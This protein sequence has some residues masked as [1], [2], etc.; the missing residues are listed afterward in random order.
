LEEAFQR[1][2]ERV[3]SLLVQNL[4]YKR[5]S[6]ILEAGCGKGQ[7]TVP[8][9]RRT[10]KTGKNI[11]I[12][13]LDTSVGP[14]RGHL[15]VLKKNLRKEKLQDLVVPVLADVRNMKSV[16]NESVDILLS[17]ELLCDLDRRGLEKA[18]REFYRVLKPGGQM[19]HAELSPV[20]ENEAQELLIEADANSLETSE[21]R[22]EWFSPFSD[23]VAAIMH[24]T[25]F[26]NVNVGYFETEI[27]MKYETAIATLRQ[28][29]IA[30][31]F[32][33]NRSGDI[34]KFGL[35]FPMEHVIFCE[36]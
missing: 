30:P 6:V 25:G 31:A 9:A 1:M 2:Y 21:P 15:N 13:A 36:K 12:I 8:L 27:R 26:K 3:V 16:H 17:H 34:R 28:W 32:I 33:K 20:P 11:R 4:D 24:K 29:K 23:E 7:L 19:A 10:R 18:M 14:Y 35:E 5:A 22:P